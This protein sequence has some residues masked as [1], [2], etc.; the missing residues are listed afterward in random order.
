MAERT[1]KMKFANE[2]DVAYRFRR[3]GSEEIPPLVLKIAVATHKKR[4]D[5]CYVHT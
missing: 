3:S 1:L 4:G 2:D 5:A